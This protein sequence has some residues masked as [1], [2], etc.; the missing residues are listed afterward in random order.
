MNGI[1]RITSVHMSL[2]L[3]SLKVDLNTLISAIRASRIIKK[4]AIVQKSKVIE[5]VNNSILFKIV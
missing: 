5:G 1:K 3:A 2:L 4:E